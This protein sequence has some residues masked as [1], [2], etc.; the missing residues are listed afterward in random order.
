[1][2]FSDLTPK[3]V[4]EIFP[5][6]FHPLTIYC[7]SL[8]CV[9]RPLCLSVCLLHILLFPSAGSQFTILQSEPL[10]PGRSKEF[11]LAQYLL[12]H[13]PVSEQS[14]CV[15]LLGQLQRKLLMIAKENQSSFLFFFSVLCESKSV[16]SCLQ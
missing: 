12:I 11:D 8:Q 15:K 3:V 5:A 10:N 9:I 13:F 7:Q 1:M 16:Y 4:C 14:A 6:A 2:N